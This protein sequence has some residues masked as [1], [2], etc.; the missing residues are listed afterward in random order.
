MFDI[1]KAEQF[2]Q[3]QTQRYPL[4]EYYRIVDVD[5]YE[6]YAWKKSHLMATGEH[7]YQ[8]WSRNCACRNCVSRLA[9]DENRSIIKMETTQDHRIF[10][11]ESVPLKGLGD[12]YALELIKEVTD[13]LLFADHDQKNNVM[14]TEIIY[15][16]NELSTHDSYTGLYNKR[17]MEHELK[18]E[19]SDWKE[20][21]PL[22]IALLDID[23]FKT[24]NDN[25][26]HLV[27]DRVIL[28]LSEALKECAESHNGWACRIG[29]DEFLILF[30]GSMKRRR[31]R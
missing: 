27:G 12:H 6:V 1:E 24:V 28:A 8:V 23:Q 25:Y 31:N 5:S 26:G 18:R 30:R 7:C 21:R 20:E 2:I 14:L 11:I 10:L 13:N 16:M 9:V 17:F 3:K 19:I 22:T 4:F 29:G 15:K